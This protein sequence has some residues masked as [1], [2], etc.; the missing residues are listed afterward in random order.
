MQVQV[1]AFR[2]GFGGVQSFSGDEKKAF[3]EK[4][5]ANCEGQESHGERGRRAFSGE[6]GGAGGADILSMGRRGGELFDRERHGYG[7]AV[8]ADKYGSA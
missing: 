6:V 8:G 2:K 4:C 7:D 1:L 5:Y 3:S